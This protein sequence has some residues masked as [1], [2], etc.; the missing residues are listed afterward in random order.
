MNDTQRAAQLVNDD[1]LG[2]R[3]F[4]YSN[5]QLGEEERDLHE[6][7]PSSSSHKGKQRAY[8]DSDDPDDH[9]GGRSS[10]AWARQS[11]ENGAGLR[12][13]SFS[14]MEAGGGAAGRRGSNRLSP[15]GRMS[16]KA[17]KERLRVLWWRSAAINL[18]FILSWSVPNKHG[19]GAR[20]FLLCSPLC[21][22]RYTFSTLIS[23]YSASSPFF[24]PLESKLTL[25]SSTADKWMF[26][27][28]HYNFPYPLFVTSVHMLVQWTLSAIT[29][30]FFRHLRP[31]TR[32]SAPDYACVS[33]S[34]FLRVSCTIADPLP[35]MQREGRAVWSR[36]GTRHRTFQPLSPNN[37]PLLLQ[38]AFPLL[39]ASLL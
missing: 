36:D 17:E 11:E 18:L 26:S 30:Y 3:G 16:D 10:A 29:L 2:S 12:R 28:D 13:N 38:Y 34:F 7:S 35:R 24:T 23:V 37:H 32:P 31:T 6:L 22:C 15:G 19:G 9:H 14:R 33:F 21:V 5:L 1:A 8:H 27:E 39:F 20:F 4:A 25:S